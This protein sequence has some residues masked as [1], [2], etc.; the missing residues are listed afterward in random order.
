MVLFCLRIPAMSLPGDLVT[1]H[2][3]QGCV[4]GRA[5]PATP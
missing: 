5:D 1:T 4:L 3:D 2:K